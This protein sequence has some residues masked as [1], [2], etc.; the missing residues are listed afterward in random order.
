VYAYSIP[1]SVEPI[2]AT[3]KV[4]PYWGRRERREHWRGVKIGQTDRR[5]SEPG[6]S[7]R[8]HRHT[9][10]DFGEC[11]SLVGRPPPL[12][13]PRLG[14]SGRG[15]AVTV[16]TMLYIEWGRLGAIGD[17][18]VIPC[19][20]RRDIATALIDAAKLNCKMLGCSAISLIITPEGDARHGL[21]AFYGRFGFIQSGRSI[22]THMLDG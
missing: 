13:R 10:Y 14:G 3:K 1:P 4:P 12:D 17:L 22:L 8:V 2:V 19:A 5:S 6:A 21:T 18:Y 15:W 16:T 7:G 11:S 20:R 9:V